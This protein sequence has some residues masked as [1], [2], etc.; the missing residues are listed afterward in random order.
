MNIYEVMERIPHRYP[1]LMI[2]KVEACEPDKYIIT[3]K[4]ITAGEPF[5]QGHFPGF[6]VVPGVL[7]IEAMAQSTGILTFETMG[8]YPHDD[9]IFML[10]GVDNA[11]FKKQVTPGDVLTIRAEIARKARNVWKFS[12]QASVDGETVCTATIVGALTTRS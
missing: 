8:G 11:R 12:S 10:V 1:F 2:D 4:N 9:S 6:P 3:V 7:I 5:F